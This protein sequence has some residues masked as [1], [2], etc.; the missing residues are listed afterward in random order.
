MSGIG[1]QVKVTVRTRKGFLPKT[2][3]KA[4]IRGALRK[5]R[6]PLTPWINPFMRKVCFGKAS[7]KTEIIGDVS[8]PNAKNSRKI[9]TAAQ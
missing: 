8:N 6:K 1:E 2:S 3:D 4:P 5:E 7:S 9:T